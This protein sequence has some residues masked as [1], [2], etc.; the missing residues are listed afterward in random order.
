MPPVASII[1]P[2]YE[3]GRQSSVDG[4]VDLLGDLLESLERTLAGEVVPHEILILD[5][6][7]CD[8]SLATARR[9]SERIGPDGRAFCR[10]IEQ[11]HSG[12]LSVA[13]NRLMEESRG[14]I[15]CRMDGDVRVLTPGWLGR[16]VSHFEARPDLGVLGARQLDHAGRLHSLGDLLVHPHGYQHI[17]MGATGP[18]PEGLVEHD[19][20]MGCFHM[21]R[22]SAWEEAGPY[23]ETIPR[24]QTVDLG[25]RLLRAGWRAMTDPDISYEHRLGPRRGRQTTGDSTESLAHSRRR[26]IDKWG[27]DRILPDRSVLRERLGE[28]LVPRPGDPG[29]GDGA[30][31]DEARELVENRVALVRGTIRP[32]IPTRI[33]LYGCGDGSV[34]NA[35]VGHGIGV[36]GIE[37]RAD[38]LEAARRRKVAEPEWIVPHPVGGD[39]CIPVGDGEVDLMLVDRAV[40]RGDDPLALLREAHRILA[41]DGILLLIARWRT[42]EAQMA[43]PRATDAFTPS[44]LRQ[45]V[46]AAGLF[47]SVGFTDRP[48]PNPEP[49]SL[50]YALRTLPGADLGRA[51]FDGIGDPFL[52]D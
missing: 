50:L 10:L 37:Y 42:P 7:S 33:L 20:V 51:A 6:G 29:A 15:V 25:Y 31:I 8:D 13:L 39:S 3:N 40:E 17:G 41:P 32:A 19:H 23:D 18:V 44:S 43:D 4:K 45:L 48:F 24:G 9:W 28:R 2:N 38:A 47:C 22:R 11:E 14:G 27:F 52:V 26:F 36:T 1:I 5:D 35:L 21:L 46:A 12:V 49:G 34:E 16:V 30:G